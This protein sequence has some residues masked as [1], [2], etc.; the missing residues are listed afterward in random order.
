MQGGI[1]DNCFNS[2]MDEKSDKI[3]IGQN[4]NLIV[5]GVNNVNIDKKSVDV[6]CGNN[7]AEKEML[8][9]SKKSHC[10]KMFQR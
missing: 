7:G 2:E 5:G 3:N 1:E 9:T 4:P 10:Q 6:R 8:S